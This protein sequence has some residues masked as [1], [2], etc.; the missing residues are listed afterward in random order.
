[1]FVRFSVTFFMIG[2]LALLFTSAVY[3]AA[4]LTL[5]LVGFV[6]CGLTIVFGGIAVMYTIRVERLEA[7]QRPRRQASVPFV[8]DTRS[9]QRSA[10]GLG[11]VVAVAAVALAVTHLLDRGE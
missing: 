8:E 1:M 3:G 5:L 11:F 10:A 7:D 4:Y 2:V 6:S 9:D